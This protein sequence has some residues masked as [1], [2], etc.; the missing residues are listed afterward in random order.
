MLIRGQGKSGIFN[1]RSGNIQ[2]ILIHVL[3]MNSNLL[4][5]T[6]CSLVST[7]KVMVSTISMVSTKSEKSEKSVLPKKYQSKIKGF[8]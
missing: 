7:S 2:G 4:N 1:Y 3:S 6:I 8:Y 5:S